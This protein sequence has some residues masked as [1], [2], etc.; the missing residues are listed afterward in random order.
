MLPLRLMILHFSQIGFTDDLTFTAIS[1]FL[2][3]ALPLQG[4]QVILLRASSILPC[5]YGSSTPV[6]VCPLKTRSPLL[7]ISLLSSFPDIPLHPD[8]V[9]GKL[10]PAF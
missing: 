10:H 6:G 2:R 1:P 8:P 5:L 7:K 4:T 3:A 9:L